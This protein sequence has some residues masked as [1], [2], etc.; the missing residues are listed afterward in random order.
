LSI[1]QL[2]EM[3]KITEKEFEKEKNRN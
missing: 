3:L 1:D 2:E